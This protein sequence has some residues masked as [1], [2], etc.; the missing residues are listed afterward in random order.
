MHGFVTCCYWE[1]E[2]QVLF[3]FMHCWNRLCIEQAV[4]LETSNLD[5][6][7]SLSSTRAIAF[8]RAGLFKEK[9]L[10]SFCPFHSSPDVPVLLGADFI[11]SCAAC[12]CFFSQ[13]LCVWCA[14]RW[15]CWR[16]RTAL[17]TLARALQRRG[18]KSRLFLLEYF[19][20]CWIALNFVYLFQGWRRMG[21]SITVISALP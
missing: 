7:P 2:V 5:L 16:S 1:K 19:H 15:H 8:C 12:A 13:W 21:W 9:S 11:C 10:L 17:P 4:G 20:M 14:P 3:S 18:P 6:F